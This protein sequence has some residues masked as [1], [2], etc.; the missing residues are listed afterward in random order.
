MRELFIRY[1]KKEHS[2]KEV[3]GMGRFT[4]AAL[5][6]YGIETAEQFSKF[7]ER[8]VKNLLGNSGIKLLHN[9][10]EVAYV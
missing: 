10:K 3:P 6:H 8:E 4:I 1:I 5:K 2:L 9:A 7:T